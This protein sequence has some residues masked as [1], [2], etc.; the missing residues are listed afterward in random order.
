VS[1]NP[2]STSSCTALV[3]SRGT[4]SAATF[5]LM[6][7]LPV[8]L[9][10]EAGI[11][12]DSVALIAGTGILALRAGGLFAIVLQRAIRKR[13]LAGCYAG[14]A[15]AIA[16]LITLRPL[17]FAHVVSLAAVIA[18]FGVLLACA[19]VSTKSALAATTSPAGRLDAFGHLNRFIN[20]G[21]GLGA[22]VGSMLVG[23]QPLALAVIALALLI[24]AAV[25]ALKAETSPGP[26]APAMVLAANAAITRAR[27]PLLPERFGF[28]VLTGF[29]FIGVAQ[30]FS[31]LPVYVRG[32]DAEPYIGY[33]FALNA[34]I[35]GL[36]QAQILKR[37]SAIR[38]GENG[39]HLY[40]LSAALLSVSV[41]LLCLAPTAYW[42]L[43]FAAVVVFTLSEALWAPLLDVWTAEIFAGRNLT[44]AYI[45][46]SLVWGG[47]EA[48]GG[49]LSI[50][51]TAAHAPGEVGSIAVPVLAAAAV[52]G[53]SACLAPWLFARIVSP[54]ERPAD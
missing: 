41:L 10:A 46:T 24:A 36:F 33:L 30:F 18:V 17:L 6:P 47:M 49:A 12:A 40:R 25:I 35:I 19:N 48:L 43:L 38:G 13:P 32:T 21:A 4:S 8:W 15:L 2:S 28:M 7:Y 42:W 26:Q 16:T 14:A 9:L 37:A 1:T 5:V 53:C 23:R 20:A 39:P 50:R 31:C 11:S 34:A 3:W 22:I 51:Y 27:L 54:A 45:L 52:I 29:L 44:T